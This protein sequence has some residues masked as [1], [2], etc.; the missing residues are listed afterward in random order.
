M[1]NVSSFVVHNT[2]GSWGNIA[3]DL[4]SRLYSQPATISDYEPVTS[5]VRATTTATPSYYYRP[6]STDDYA[7]R[8]YE[9]N[10]DEIARQFVIGDEPE[11]E[12]EENWCE[13]YKDDPDYIE[14]FLSEFALAVA[15]GESA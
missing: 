3:A 14:Q 6:V 12:T 4:S 10:Y 13:E 15:G 9:I 2:G 5:W 1:D 8:N 11:E 7:F